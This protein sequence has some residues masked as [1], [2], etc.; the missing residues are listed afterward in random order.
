MQYGN[1]IVFFIH[2]N[3][4]ENY[5]NDGIEFFF[6]MK[7]IYYLYSLNKIQKRNFHHH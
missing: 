5:T 1:S 6:V 2:S 4:S 3:K 7:L